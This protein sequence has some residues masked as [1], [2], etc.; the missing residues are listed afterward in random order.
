MGGIETRQ[1]EGTPGLPPVRSFIWFVQYDR[2]GRGGVSI[3]YNI[4]AYVQTAG[5]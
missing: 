1:L 5:R 2:F 4:H 3:L